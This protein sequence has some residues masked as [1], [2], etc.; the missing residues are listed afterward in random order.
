MWEDT[1][2]SVLNDALDKLSHSAVGLPLDVA[3]VLVQRLQ[4]RQRSGIVPADETVKELLRLHGIAP[5]EETT[6]TKQDRF[7]GLI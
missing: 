1:E 7:W 6:W 2:F 3:D 4:E 5:G